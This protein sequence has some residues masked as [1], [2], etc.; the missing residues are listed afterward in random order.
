[1]SRR[2]GVIALQD[3]GKGCQVAFRNIR[4]KELV[5]KEK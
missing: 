1:M 2:K 4:I 3:H 5:G